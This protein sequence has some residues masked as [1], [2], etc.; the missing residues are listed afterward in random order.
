MYAKE[1]IYK[2]EIWNKQRKTFSSIKFYAFASQF[3][4]VTTLLLSHF[5]RLLVGRNEKNVVSEDN[6]RSQAGTS[7]GAKT[8]II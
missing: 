7:S 8:I 6:V 1:N 4:T 5:R 3:L 2:N